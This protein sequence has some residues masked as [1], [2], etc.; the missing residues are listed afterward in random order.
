MTTNEIIGNEN[1]FWFP[2]LFLLA[3]VNINRITH[4]ARVK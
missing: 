1:N 4:T 3:N 2:V